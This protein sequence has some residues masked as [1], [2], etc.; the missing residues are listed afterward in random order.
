MMS[1]RV[2]DAQSCTCH[3]PAGGGHPSSRPC[4]PPA[5]PSSRPGTSLR[6]DQREGPGLLLC[7]L[8]RMRAVPVR[9]CALRGQM[10]C[11]ALARV[12][13]QEAHTTDCSGCCRGR[14]QRL[15][16]LKPQSVGHKKY[17]DDLW[18]ERRPSVDPRERAFTGTFGACISR[19]GCGFHQQPVRVP[20][21]VSACWRSAIMHAR[22]ACTRATCC[23][24]EARCAVTRAHVCTVLLALSQVCCVH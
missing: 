12:V 5:H 10:Y 22:V 16:T 4:C 19:P 18:A 24:P 3:P 14:G 17:A 6:R 7:W 2:Q 13:G 1:H 21:L 23:Y 9:P 11:C 8:G 15:R 20:P